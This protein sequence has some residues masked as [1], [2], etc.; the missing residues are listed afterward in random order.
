M[1]V[2]VLC[3]NDYPLGANLFI[4][5]ISLIRAIA[6]DFGGRNSAALHHSRAATYMALDSL[7][8]A[9]NVGAIT[10]VIHSLYLSVVRCIFYLTTFDECFN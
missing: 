9:E 2:Y 8:A 1:C 7:Q 10:I 4:C 6:L 5:H 3:T